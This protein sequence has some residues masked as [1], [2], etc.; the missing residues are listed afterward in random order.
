MGGGLGAAAGM[1]EV[2]HDVSK[3]A[4]EN[5]TVVEL[6]QLVLLEG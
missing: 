6:F 5:R 1:P 3:G 2:T 4:A